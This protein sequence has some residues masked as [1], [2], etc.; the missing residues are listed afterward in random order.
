LGNEANFQQWT[1]ELKDM[2]DR[3]LEVRQLLRSGLEK[4]GTPGTWNH[5][6]DQIG[7]FS[8]TGLSPEQSTKMIEEHHVYMLKTGRISLAGLNKGNVQYVV[9]AIDAVVRLST[10][11]GAT[12]EV[13][14]SSQRLCCL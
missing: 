6:T 1:Q 9:D 13:A 5:I 8:F 10:S 14:N 11:A 4:K 3:I 12:V 2:A 7:M